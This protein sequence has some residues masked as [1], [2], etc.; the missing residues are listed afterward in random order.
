[1]T[2]TNVPQPAH[3]HHPHHQTAGA[4]LAEFGAK[5]KEQMSNFLRKTKRT[6]SSKVSRSGSSSRASS[7]KEHSEPPPAPAGGQQEPG[8]EL[9]KSSSDPHVPNV[10]SGNI[11]HIKGILKSRKNK[12]K[13]NNKSATPSVSGADE[14]ET[15]FVMSVS[16][17]ELGQY[18]HRH[19]DETFCDNK[20]EAN[21]N[22][23]DSRPEVSSGN[24]QK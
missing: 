21:A 9:Q 8:G 22:G 23:K 20:L 14:D 13:R 18:Q 16:T 3:Q 10:I 19:E 15:G 4:A 1:V 17:S 11:S 2:T 7:N 5:S 6:F 24:Q 12:N